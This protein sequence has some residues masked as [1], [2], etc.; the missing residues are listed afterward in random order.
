MTSSKNKKKA[1]AILEYIVLLLF[2]IG[3]I[4]VFQKYVARAISGRWKA[5][6]DSF[7]SGRQ[8]DPNRTKQCG[9]D[10]IYT[11]QWYDVVCYDNRCNVCFN[12][13]IDDTACENCIRSCPAPLCNAC[14]SSNDCVAG[15][16]CVSGHCQ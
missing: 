16:S 2:V 5:V 3:A 6:G 7:G 8:F 4:L 9:Y 15:Q 12:D 10:A 13:P 14:A 1:Q 11:N